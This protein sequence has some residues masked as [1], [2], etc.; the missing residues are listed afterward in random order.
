MTATSHELRAERDRL[1]ASRNASPSHIKGRFTR[2][3]DHIDDLLLIA[4]MPDEPRGR[5]ELIPADE[6]AAGMAVCDHGVIL[7]VHT[8][9]D[10][11]RAQFPLC[12]GDWH[13]RE[14]VPGVRP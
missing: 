4:H 13:I 3:I 14:S 8:D 11:I 9:G 5:I 1:V 7:A 2:K 6:L 12:D 10:W